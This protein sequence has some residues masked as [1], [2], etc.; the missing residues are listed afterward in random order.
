MFV[1]L[2]LNLNHFWNVVLFCLSCDQY[3]YEMKHF[4]KRNVFF[5]K[6]YSLTN[7]QTYTNW[8]GRLLTDITILTRMET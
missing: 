6:C 5:P 3:V 1:I 2:V 7:P 8:Y 4:Y